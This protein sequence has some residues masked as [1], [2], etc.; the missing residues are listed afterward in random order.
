MPHQYLHY[1]LLENVHMVCFFLQ[2]ITEDN[3][4]DKINIKNR[5]LGTL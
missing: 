1:L 3:Q 4:T 5:F 2:T